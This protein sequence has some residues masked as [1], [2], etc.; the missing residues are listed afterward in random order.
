M[1]E[2]GT[3]WLEVLLHDRPEE[4]HH[5]VLELGSLLPSLD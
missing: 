2:T 4:V 5:G 3:G 1:G